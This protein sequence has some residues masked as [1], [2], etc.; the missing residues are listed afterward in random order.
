M[1]RFIRLQFRLRTLLLAAI[2]LPPVVAALAPYRSWRDERLW[3]SLERAKQQRDVML[4]DWRDSYDQ[5]ETG[6]TSDADLQSARRRYFAAR[7]DVQ[8]AVKAIHARYGT[9][10]ELSQAMQARRVKK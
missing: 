1:A 2:V 5:W 3:R 10:R 6:Q 4:I 9:E 8:S 7:D